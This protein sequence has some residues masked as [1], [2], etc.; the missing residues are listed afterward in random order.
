M[1]TVFSTREEY[2]NFLSG[3]PKGTRFN[4][5]S[6]DNDQVYAL[7]T[8]DDVTP[9]EGRFLVH[10]AWLQQARDDQKS[11]LGIKPRFVAPKWIDNIFRGGWW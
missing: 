5:D 9:A 7:L 8:D 11:I 3:Y 6:T 2:Q 10:Y 4:I 1:A